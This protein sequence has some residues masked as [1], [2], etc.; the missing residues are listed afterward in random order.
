MHRLSLRSAAPPLPRFILL[1]L[2]L[3]LLGGMMAVNAQSPERA[4]QTYTIHAGAAGPGNVRLLTFYPANVQVH[5]GDT[6]VWQVHDF[7]NMRF[8]TEPLPLFVEAEVEGQT[9]LTLNAD[10]LFPNVE[11]GAAFQGSEINTGAPVDENAI[12]DGPDSVWTFSVVMDAPPGTYVYL[13]DIHPGMI[14][15][16]TIVDDSI[17]VPDPQTVAADATEQMQRDIYNGFLMSHEI[18]Q[19]QHPNPQPPAEGEARVLTGLQRG[20]ISV[21]RFFPEVTVI[22]AGQSVTWAT[23]VDG[24]VPH[25]VTWPYQPREEFFKFQT[26]N[27]G[28]NLL[29]VDSV[30]LIPTVENGGDWSGEGF[31][32]SGVLLPGD[33]F[34]ARFPEPGVYPFMDIFERGMTGVVV[35]LAEE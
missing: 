20:G 33:T 10:I 14:G 31:L 22:R 26:S 1:L 9:A 25:S 4:P 28:M 15:T 35:V 23:P 19:H 30:L 17:A 6:I 34:T 7:H 8:D 21:D 3:V 29:V 12:I 27:D 16:I 11:D 18:E 13:C 2:L 5:R 32:H 24:N